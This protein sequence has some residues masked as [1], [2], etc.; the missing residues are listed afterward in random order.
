MYDKNLSPVGWYVCSYL[1]RFVELAWPHKD[2]AE[3]K[4]LSWEDTVLVK[5]GSMDEAF[6][7]TVVLAQKAAQPYKGGLD[8]LTCNGCLRA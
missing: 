5:A 1:L 6:D 8:W 7:K 2:D 3:A 4:F